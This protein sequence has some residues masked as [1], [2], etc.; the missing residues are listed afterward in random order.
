MSGRSIRLIDRD[1]LLATLE[2]DIDVSVTG[3]ENMEAVKRCLQEI[4]DD[5]KESPVMD[6]VE[7]IR[8]KDCKYWLPHS[9]FGFDEDNEEYYDYCELLVPDDDY[10]AITRKADDFCSRAERKEE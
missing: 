8:C 7:V 4:L 3:E 10:Y 5:V 9:Q 2:Q 1:E 6:A